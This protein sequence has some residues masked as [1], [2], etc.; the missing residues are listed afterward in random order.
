MAPQINPRHSENNI[1]GAHICRE[2]QQALQ[3]LEQD[4]EH[5]DT[6]LY[7]YTNFR[8]FICIYRQSRGT[9]DKVI[10]S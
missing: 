4:G 2:M 7:C 9:D 1:S 6:S 10:V 3:P 8:H 5:S